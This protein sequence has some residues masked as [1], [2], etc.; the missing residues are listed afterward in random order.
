M[1]TESDNDEVI[2]CADDGELIAYNHPTSVSH[3]QCEK[4]IRRKNTIK[5][6]NFFDKDKIVNDYIAN[7]KSYFLLIVTLN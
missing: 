1:N 6:P 3:A 2:Y 5:N 4:Y 7:N